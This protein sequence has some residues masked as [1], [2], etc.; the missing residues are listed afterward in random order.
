MKVGDIVIDAFTKQWVVYQIDGLFN[1][2]TDFKTQ[3]QKQILLKSEIF[4]VVPKPDNVKFMFM[5]RREKDLQDV[6]EY[7]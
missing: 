1:Y 2:V 6:K 3:T 4:E 5:S 7:L